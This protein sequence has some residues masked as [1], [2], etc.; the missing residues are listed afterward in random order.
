MN[1]KQYLAE[2]LALPMPDIMEATK[3]D[4]SIGA[5]AYYSAQTVVNLIKKEREACAKACIEWGE[6]REEIEVFH[7][8]AWLIRKRSNI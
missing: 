4:D 2:I 7:E 5:G 8:C 1:D 6:H 3:I